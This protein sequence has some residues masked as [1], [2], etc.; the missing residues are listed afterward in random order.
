MKDANY[1]LDKLDLNIIY[2]K[3]LPCGVKALLIGKNIYILKGLTQAD[4]ICTIIEEI[5]HKLYSNG[6]ILD[7]SKIMNRKQEFFARRKAHEFLVPRSLIEEC[8]QRGLR[9]YYEIAEHLGI[10]EEF[11]KEACEHYIQKYG[12]ILASV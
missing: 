4:E 3:S 12:Q 7:V 6:N 9:E 10:T 8:Y 11:L 1:L 2:E 5:S